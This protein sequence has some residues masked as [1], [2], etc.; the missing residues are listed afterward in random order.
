MKHI[1]ALACIS[2]L[3]FSGC[4]QDDIRQSQNDEGMLTIQFSRTGMDEGTATDTESQIHTLNGYYFENGMLKETFPAIKINEDGTCVLYISHTKGSLYF[5]ANSEKAVPAESLKEHVTTLE[6][7]LKLKA[8]SEDMVSEYILMNGKTDLNEET[9]LLPVS[10][11]RAVARIDLDSPFQD[12]EVN[13]VTIKDIALTGYIHQQ[14]APQSTEQTETTN[15][16]RSFDGQAFQNGKLSLFYLPE[17][18]HTTGHEVEILMKANGGW[19]R[20]R[21]VLPALQRN[22]VYTLKVYGNGSELKVKTVTDNWDNGSSSDSELSYKGIVDKAHSQLSEGVTLNERGDTV[23]VPYWESHFQLTLAGEAGTE[24]S[25]HG[26]AEDVTL[27]PVN[28]SRDLSPIARFNITSKQKMPGGKYEYVYLDVHKHNVQTGRVV[29]VFSPNPVQMDGILQFDENGHCNF[30][31]YIDGELASI[32]LPEGKNIALRFEEGEDRWMK[33]E[34]KENN[35]YRLLGGWKPN[36]PKADGRLQT[37]TLVISSTDGERTEIYTIRRLNWGLP[38]VNVNGVWWCKYNLRGNVKSFSDQITISADPAVE[39]SLADYLSACS[40]DDF[41]HVLGNQYQA[42]NPDGLKLTHNGSEFTYEG[43]ESQTDNFGTML[44][45]EMAPD[46][47]QIPDYNNYRFYTWG[48]NC[49]LAYF[50][51][52]VFNNGLGQRLNFRVIER[53]ATFQGTSYGPISFY[54]FE[55]EG[56]H[57]TLCGLGHQWNESSISSMMILF[58]T[59]G[60]STKTWYI[61][62]SSQSSGEGNWFKYAANNA[63]KTRTIRCIKTPV[64]YIYE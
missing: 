14:S 4:Q 18:Y 41:L 61:E 24:V 45:T 31:R 13:S 46:G 21:T 20:L 43:Y 35:T 9:Q 56:N 33:L 63:Q 11:Q 44:P 16:S 62:G 36:D 15:L 27:T 30:N 59:Y 6:E 2:L 37:G 22:T 10:L 42:G 51:P 34:E 50:N 58:A 25:I 5:L 49:N 40:D 1:F 17:Q 8:S 55:Y 47:Y 29:L 32:T 60:N 3:L 52:G 53:N 48:N 19:H 28:L 64:E 39:T 12:T 7:F 57:L 54:D 23:F 38:V 26:K